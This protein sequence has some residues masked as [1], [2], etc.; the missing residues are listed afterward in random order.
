ML[1]QG[2][3]VRRALPPTSLHLR[4]APFAAPVTLRPVSAKGAPQVKKEREIV[5][6]ESPRRMG[7]DYEIKWFAGL[8]KESLGE[9]SEHGQRAGAAV[10][11]AGSLRSGGLYG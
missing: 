9:W 5:Q 6:R 11:E 3:V 4:S 10:A 8:R 1:E 7:E 2:K